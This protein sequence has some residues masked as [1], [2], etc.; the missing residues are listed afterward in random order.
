MADVP[1][2]GFRKYW[3]QVLSS[4]KSESH[5]ITIKYPEAAS[6]VQQVYKVISDTEIL[7]KCPPV[8]VEESSQWTTIV[9]S[10]KDSNILQTFK[11]E[12]A[13]Q[14]T[15]RHVHGNIERLQA[16]LKVN[17]QTGQSG[18]ANK[19]SLESKAQDDDFQEVKRG[20]SYF[21]NGN[22]ETTMSRPNQ[23]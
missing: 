23:F 9:N 16:F 17:T 4:L 19:T 10:A 18:V 8:R 5:A 20:K 7:A 21:S 1:E 14:R 13:F 12:A 2:P 6:V 3:R 11:W 22:S 15:L